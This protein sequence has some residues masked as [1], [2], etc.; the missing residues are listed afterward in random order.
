MA[1]APVNSARGVASKIAEKLK[2]QQDPTRKTIDSII[3]FISEQEM[4]LILD[5]FEHVLD[6]SEQVSQLLTSCSRLK[7]L[8]TSRIVLGITGEYEYSVSQLEYPERGVPK[9]I[10]EL[11]KYPAIR[12]FVQRS[13]AAKPS[14]QITES[15]KDAIVTIC[16]QLDGLPLALEL[17]AARTKIFS[18]QALSK[19]LAS[20]H[21]I[22]STKA[23][24]HPDRHRTLKNAIEWSYH[25]LSPE[26]QTIFR[27]L[28]V[29][30]GG[31]TLEAAEEV[32]FQ[33]YINN[34]EFIDLMTSLVDKSL[35]YQQ[36]QTDGEPRFHMLQTIRS[37]GLERLEAS[38]EIE[39][40][41]S[42]YSEYYLNLAKRAEK[43][44]IGA[45][46]VRWLE[47]IEQ[48]LDNIRVLF[49]W[50]IENEQAEFGLQLAVSIYRYWII[51][52][53]M[54]E[55]S[56]WLKRMLDLSALLAPDKQRCKA[57]NA[58]GIMFALTNN[59]KDTFAVFEESQQLAKQL[60]FQEGLG[61]VLNHLGWAYF[62]EA[63]FERSRKTSLEAK[64]IHTELGNQRGISVAYNNLGSCA[65]YQGA[66]EDSIN[67]FGKGIEIR[68]DIL[69]DRGYAFGLINSA[70]TKVYLGEYDSALR[71]LG[72][73]LEI[74][75]ELR[76]AQLIAWAK[77]NTAFHA[78]RSNELQKSMLVAAEALQLWD[79]AGTVTGALRT[80]LILVEIQLKN[81][82]ETSYSGESL[83]T[84]L[85]LLTELASKVSIPDLF[86]VNL[87]KARLLDNKSMFKEAL[88]I[89]LDNLKRIVECQAHLFVSD[90]LDVAVRIF[91]RWNLHKEALMIL[92]YTDG[93]REKIKLQVP[94]VH[95]SE[96]QKLRE[97]LC[98]RYSQPELENFKLKS[99]ELNLED[100]ISV[101]KKIADQRK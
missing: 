9:S 74:L 10:E 70:Q 22:L 43:N 72:I 64:R 30:G 54:R 63:K 68:K 58:Y 45:D 79:Q 44:L 4:V 69:D 56:Q 3:D 37:F 81:N 46:Q 98:S 77:H 16:N 93:F 59:F 38:L 23:A 48:E 49:V 15:N 26:E 96:H 84:E 2:I 11:N 88:S 31:C 57:L 65:L 6:A 101:L 40:V 55:G 39:D 61:E 92:V 35:A 19:R 100:I 27:R 90:F 8:V 62:W 85:E 87:A 20:S 36:E 13:K 86:A 78:L 91:T 42:R 97:I 18:P 99:K 51:R 17:A 28:S 29:F 12:L 82:S 52:S 60:G 5:N 67:F 75:S 80:R 95:Y 53:M 50:C 89:C 1:L 41:L 32:C 33:G 66:F 76:D 25:L 14:F 7:V 47:I 94:V 34:L 83:E 73:A 71:E 24:T 21:D